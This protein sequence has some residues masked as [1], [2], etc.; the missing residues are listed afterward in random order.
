M[1][2]FIVLIYTRDIFGSVGASQNS[3]KCG[4]S[5]RELRFV[6]EKGVVYISRFACCVGHGWD[7]A[8]S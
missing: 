7:A 6:R 2:Q 4:V 5:D 1:N 8:L 3:Q